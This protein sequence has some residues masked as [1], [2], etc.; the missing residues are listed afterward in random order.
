MKG[1]GILLVV[2][3]GIGMGV[4]GWLRLHRR[5]EVLTRFLRVVERLAENI[6]YS[7]APIEEILIQL[8]PDLFERD[9]STADP[10]ERLG[11]AIW[12]Q[13]TGWGLSTDDRHLLRGFADGIGRSDIDG[14]MRFC[15]EYHKAIDGHLAQAREE[16][17]VKGR[18]FVIFGVCGGL[19]AALLM[20]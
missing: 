17:R 18:L 1:I 11:K 7:A 8:L 15:G 10:R 2:L 5:V 13:G 9:C 4:I 16:L 20:W 12:E 14:E 3:T 6:R 19:L